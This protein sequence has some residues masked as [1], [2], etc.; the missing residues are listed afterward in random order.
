MHTGI[1]MKVRVYF[2]LSIA[3]M[4]QYNSLMMWWLKQMWEVEWKQIMLALLY[5]HGLL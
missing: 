1:I 4:T 2:K 3:N 5:C